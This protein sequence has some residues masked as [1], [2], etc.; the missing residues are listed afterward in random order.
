MEYVLEL[1]KKRKSVYK[2]NPKD[3]DKLIKKVESTWHAP[4]SEKHT[5][6]MQPFARVPEIVEF[7]NGALIDY[8]ESTND[9]GRDE[10]GL[11]N[12][13]I[14]DSWYLFTLLLYSDKVEATI[15]QMVNT[16]IEN[17]N[18]DLS[19]ARR[20]LHFCN[21]KVYTHQLKTVEDYFKEHNKNTKIY[22]W[23][24]SLDVTPPDNFQ[25]EFRLGFGG[26]LESGKSANPV[27]NLH[28]V[29]LGNEPKGDGSSFEIQLK[30]R[31]YV[32]DATW[33]DFSTEDFVRSRKGKFQLSQVPNL[34]NLPTLIKELE[35][36]FGITFDKNDVVRYCTRGFKNKMNIQKWFQESLNNN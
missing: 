13:D 4:T 20:V 19:I 26:K 22:K 2:G 14:K 15:E 8:F 21:N 33:D 35:E 17:K 3:L 11:S 29:V 18:P 9:F 23:L 34:E 5:K 27:D 7:V 30:D 28:I 1:L 36:I 31:D 16:M 32:V 10:L 25:W 24:D 6:R 12:Y